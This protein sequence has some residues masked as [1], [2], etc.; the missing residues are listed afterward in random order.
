[1]GRVGITKEQVFDAADALANEGIQ[2]TVK[3]VRKRIGGSY[4]TITPHLSAWK[5][6]HAGRG[7]SDVPDVPDT[8]TAA[9]RQV[10]ALAWKAAQA[11]TQSERDG[12][13]AARREMDKERAEMTH[14][15]DELE[16]KV[17]TT[18][19]ARAE[20]ASALEQEGARYRKAT[21][22]LTDL[23]VTNARLE[24]RVANTTK[25]GD[26]LAEQVSRLEEHLAQLAEEK[27][28]KA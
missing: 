5:E 15:I 13:S 27:R 8:V 23:R 12:L 10:W 9:M 2:P 26:E 16:Q 3:E 18:E 28:G 19:D 7:V 6:A 11:D 17:S 22:D 25:R 14:E 1:M 4:S 20:L 24:E 21:D